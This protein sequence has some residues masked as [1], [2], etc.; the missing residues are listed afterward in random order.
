[1]HMLNTDV[2]V[3]TDFFFFFSFKKK[4]DNWA[5]RCESVSS[6]ICGQRRPRSDCASAQSNQDPHCPL[7]EPLDTTI[8]MSR[9]Q[10]L[11]GTLQLRRMIQI[12]AFCAY[13]KT[14]CRLARPN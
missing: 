3:T 5:S 4:K 1:M 2:S 10:G 11:Y 9:E 7:T 6:G 12:C 14:H 13:S 8:C